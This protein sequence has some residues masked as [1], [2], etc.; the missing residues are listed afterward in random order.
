[1]NKFTISLISIFLLCG[2]ST[3]QEVTKPENRRTIVLE[4][5]VNESYRIILGQLQKC[6][7]PSFTGTLYPDNQ[8]ARIF[9]TNGGGMVGDVH[10][11]KG[12]DTSHTELNYYKDLCVFCTDA[13][14]DMHILKVKKWVNENSTDC[15]L[16]NP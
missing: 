3:M 15:Y 1:M 4:K 11:L 2:C 14:A 8:T 13:G 12:L 6:L 7:T 5:S 16:S 10:D 9:I